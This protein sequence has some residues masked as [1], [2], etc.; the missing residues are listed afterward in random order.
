M[1]R[2]PRLQAPG[3]V[4]H[5]IARGNERREVF[6]DDPDREDYLERLTR[7][8]ER[9]G[10]RLYAYCLMPNHVHLAVEQGSA[11]LSAFMHALQSS[12]T[13]SFNRRHGRV[14]HL[15]QGRYK[16]FLVD[17]D[18][19]FVALVRYI[20]ENP[21]K[22]GIVREPHSYKWSSDRFFRIGV[23]P[24]WLDLDRALA[25]LGSSRREA[26]RTYRD[27]MADR[28]GSAPEYETLVAY[29]GSIKG[30]EGFARETLRQ[31]LMGTRRRRTW[32][33]EAVARAVAASRGLTLDHL[34]AGNRRRDVSRLRFMSAYLGRER[35]GIPIAEA[36]R[37]FRREGS[38]LAHGVRSLEEQ[39]DRDPEL[40]RQVERIAHNAKM[41]A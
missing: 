19:Y 36:A 23:G 37:L 31:V 9:F 3:T 20:H 21:V 12:Y 27:L 39:L 8:R 41:H 30:D 15:F 14:G 5:L 25:L 28:C 11:S 40:R 26:M 4:H 35:F 33:A 24:P 17:C 2:P 38:S 29:E 16:S 7:Y 1:A 32:T 34:A 13:Q 18:R 6:R 10:F 22:A